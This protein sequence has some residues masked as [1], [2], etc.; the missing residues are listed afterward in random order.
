MKILKIMI[1]LLILTLS[2][3]A[4]CAAENSTSDVLS[5]DSQEVLEITP[6]DR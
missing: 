2:V 1:V 4:V 6:N 5:A 3:G